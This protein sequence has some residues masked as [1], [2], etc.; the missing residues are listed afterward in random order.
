MS[1]SKRLASCLLGAALVC[2]SSAALMAQDHAAPAADEH[3]IE[4]PAEAAIDP[5]VLD[6]NLAIFSLVVFV[7]LML[8]LKK[9]AWGP[10][11]RSLEG[12][13]QGI[14][15][16][17]SEAERNHAEARRCWPTTSASCTAPRPKS[18]N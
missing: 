18:A 2:W 1:C 13:E 3:H 7:I 15:S 16:H 14:A 11:I 6:P 10:I 12:R 4:T 8:V 9:F 5:L 17:L